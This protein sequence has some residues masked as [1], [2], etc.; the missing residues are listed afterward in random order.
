MPYSE[1][2]FK[3]IINGNEATSRQLER[4]GNDIFNKPTADSKE[5]NGR[6]IFFKHNQLPEEIE[7][8]TIIIKFDIN[9]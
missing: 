5:V 4:C 6:H 1:I 7:E 2:T 9:E 3:L 8:D